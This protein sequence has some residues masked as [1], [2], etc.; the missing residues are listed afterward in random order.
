MRG[1]DGERQERHLLPARPQ[2]VAQ[3]RELTRAAL[4]SWG[5]DALRDPAALV[6]SELVT[7]ALTHARSEMTLELR[8]GEGLLRISVTDAS[9]DSPRRQDADPGAEGGRGMHM[10]AEIASGWGI[11]HLPEGKRVWAEIAIPAPPGR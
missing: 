10:V 2:A 8:C 9:P 5:L 4:A 3:A 7:N 6:V 1:R 11:E